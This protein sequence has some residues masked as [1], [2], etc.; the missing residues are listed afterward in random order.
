M[1]RRSTAA[2]AQHGDPLKLFLLG[3]PKIY[4]LFVG[5]ESVPAL[6]AIDLVLLNNVRPHTARQGRNL[7]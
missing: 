3:N 4:T 1:R 2:V 6:L 5:K 7:L